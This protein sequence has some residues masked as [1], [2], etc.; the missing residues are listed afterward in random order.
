MKTKRERERERQRGAC[1][2][3]NEVMKKKKNKGGNKERKENVI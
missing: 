3:R 1:E 2:E